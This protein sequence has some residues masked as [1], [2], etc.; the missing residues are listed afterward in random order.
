MS[1]EDEPLIAIMNRYQAQ[2]EVELKAAMDCAKGIE[3]WLAE[4]RELHAEALA[5]ARQLHR[6][7]K[8][9]RD[10]IREHRDPADWWK[11]GLEDE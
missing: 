4:G 6:N 7:A 2:I 5:C 9:V 11:Y 10:A 1:D 8:E 3:R